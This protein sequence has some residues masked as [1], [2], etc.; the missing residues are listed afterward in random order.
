MH[1]WWLTL[2][3]AFCGK[4]VYIDEA[5]HLYR[6]HT[7]NT[8]GAK[9]DKNIFQRYFVRIKKLFKFNN[10]HDTWKKYQDVVL[11]QA[12]ELQNRYQNDNNENVKILNEF[13]DI[14]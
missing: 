12:E 4:I 9:K 3:A 8:I 11:K 7:N 14:R 10:M 13:I 5:L 1:D 2:V 6:Q